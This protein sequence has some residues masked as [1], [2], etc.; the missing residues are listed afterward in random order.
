M[1]RS[2]TSSDYLPSDAPTALCIL[3]LLK[4]W[5]RSGQGPGVSLL[6]CSLT[7]NLALSRD[8]LQQLAKSREQM[9]GKK[10]R[11]N[12]YLAK[13]GDIEEGS[14]LW[15][16]LSAVDKTKRKQAMLQKKE[17]LRNPNFFVS[18]TRLCIRNLPGAMTEKE[19]KQ[20]CIKACK[21][22]ATKANPKIKQV[23]KTRIADLDCIACI[24]S[25]MPSFSLVW[26]KG[27]I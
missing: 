12:L 18:K 9:C 25:P 5:F 23:G 21:Q 6:G 15:A 19:L 27:I 26:A 22:R 14:Q 8:A 1:H 7:V 17:K 20:M 11:R 24:Q 4:C 16:E 3:R 13:E 10:D 2:A